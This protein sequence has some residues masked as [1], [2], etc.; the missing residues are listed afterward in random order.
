[1]PSSQKDRSGAGCPY[2][3]K[4]R[5]MS[6]EGRVRK[7]HMTHEDLDRQIADL[8]ARPGADTLEIV[9][10]K[11]RKLAIKEELQTLQQD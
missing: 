6:I 1:M 2:K 8:E 5:H 11:K 4:E 7:L 3:K 9:E 10:L